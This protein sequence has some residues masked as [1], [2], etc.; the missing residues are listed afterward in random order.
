MPARAYDNT[1]FVA[2]CNQVGENG[3][4]LD[5]SGVSFICDPRGVVIAQSER[6]DREEMV[7]ADLKASDLAE[8]RKVPDAFFRHF[9]RPELYRAWAT[10]AR[11]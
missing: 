8:A 3:A 7:V 2:V 4:G 10:D 5:F 9:R 6:G 11:L 1:V